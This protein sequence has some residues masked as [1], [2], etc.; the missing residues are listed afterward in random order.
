M[1][2]ER[3]GADPIVLPLNRMPSD[4]TG[5]PDGESFDWGPLDVADTEMGDTKITDWAMSNCSKGLRVSRFLG[6][7][8]LSTAH[9]IVGPE[10]LLRALSARRNSITSLYPG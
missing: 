6:R 9:S 10:S 3:E 7:R 4:R 2:F 1:S 8:I 5:K